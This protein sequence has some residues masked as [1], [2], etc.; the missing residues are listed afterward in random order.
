MEGET[1]CLSLYME[2]YHDG[3]ECQSLFEAHTNPQKEAGRN[4]NLLSNGM[5]VPGS[6][7]RSLG[8]VNLLRVGIEGSRRTLMDFGHTL[9]QARCLVQAVQRGSCGPRR[10]PCA[11]VACQ[12]M[13]PDAPL[14]QDAKIT[15]STVQ[16][17]LPKLNRHSF[18]FTSIWLANV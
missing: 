13:P 7:S 5:G 10:H 6:R 16:P 2:N 12:K 8:V 3:S 14:Q 15:T 11:H 1:Q 4:Q 9:A 17:L 18:M